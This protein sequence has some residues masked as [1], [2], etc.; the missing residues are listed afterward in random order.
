M[1]LGG[2]GKTLGRAGIG[3]GTG[4]AAISGAG[5]AAIGR[6]GGGGATG[7]AGGRGGGGGTGGRMNAGGGGGG[8]DGIGFDTGGG[9]SGTAA[10]AG[11][12][13][14]GGRE[15]DCDVP[16]FAARAGM[17]IRTVSRASGFGGFRGGRVMRTVSFFGPPESLIATKISLQ[18]ACGIPRGCHSLSGRAPKKSA[19]SQRAGFVTRANRSRDCR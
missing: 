13:G 9:V 16:P 7:G 11:D 10:R 17:F 5:A 2:G 1:S 18:E 15:G 3:G 14:G 12:P 19:I 6:G 8:A 4:G